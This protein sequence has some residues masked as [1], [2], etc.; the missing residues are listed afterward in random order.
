M[1]ES[2]EYSVF[3]SIHLFNCNGSGKGKKEQSQNWPKYALHDCSYFA[4]ANISCIDLKASALP[5]GIL[6]YPYNSFFLNLNT[7]FIPQA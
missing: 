7:C 1:K 4:L 3:V 5:S 2:I 6:I